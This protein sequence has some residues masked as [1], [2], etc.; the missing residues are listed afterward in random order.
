MRF[1]S[2]AA[3]K[4]RPTV[5]RAADQHPQCQAERAG[6]AGCGL[7]AKFS[8]KIT[9]SSESKIKNKNKIKTELMRSGGISDE[10]AL[11]RPFPFTLVVNNPN[12]SDI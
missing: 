1:A 4:N 3:F 7:V 5:H 8:S 12:E 10:D 9:N 11:N 6:C 2:F